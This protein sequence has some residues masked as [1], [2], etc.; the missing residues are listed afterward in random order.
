MEVKLKEAFIGMKRLEA[1]DLVEKG[2]KSGADPIAVLKA[3]Q[4]AMEVIGK[5]FETGE[6]FLS[7][8]I[9]SS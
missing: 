3:C 6:Y 5:R 4:E 7:E 2:L 8:L 1:V 9:Y